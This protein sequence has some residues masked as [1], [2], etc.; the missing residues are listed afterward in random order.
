MQAMLQQMNFA[1]VKM[2]IK[3]KSEQES[4]YFYYVKREA[5]TY[6]IAQYKSTLL[7]FLT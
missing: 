5:S 1:K 6:N 7:V 3:E 4:S 2:K